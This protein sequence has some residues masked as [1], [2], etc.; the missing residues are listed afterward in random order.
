MLKVPDCEYGRSICLGHTM[1][2]SCRSMAMG[3]HN[4]CAPSARR[5]C[6]HLTINVRQRVHRGLGGPHIPTSPRVEPRSTEHGIKARFEPHVLAQVLHP[7][8][9][10]F[11]RVAHRIDDET[12]V[13]R[14]NRGD[15]RGVISSQAMQWESS[16]DDSC[17]IPAHVQV[18]AHTAPSIVPATCIVRSSVDVRIHASYGRDSSPTR[19]RRQ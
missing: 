6:D 17:V 13:P 15:L 1:R 19:P 12:C 3:G 10:L 14:Y 9:H 11:E 7:R 5:K 4:T 18:P 8:L 16:T 2:C